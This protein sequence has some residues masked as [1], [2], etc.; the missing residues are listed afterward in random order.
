MFNS[1]SGKRDKDAGW[2]SPRKRFSTP[3]TPSKGLDSRSTSGEDPF[4]LRDGEEDDQEDSQDLLELADRAEMGL[5]REITTNFA[6]PVVSMQRCIVMRKEGKLE[7]RLISSTLEIM[8]YARVSADRQKIDIFGFD[9]TEEQQADVSFRSPFSLISSGRTS[10]QLV[11][12]NCE[13]CQY[14]PKHAFCAC[15]GKQQVA[16]VRHSTKQ[17]G[18]GVGNCLDVS[19]PALA[20]DGVP[21]VWC[22]LMG[23]HDLGSPKSKE[24]RGEALSLITKSPSWNTEFQ[25]LVLEFIGRTVIA[26]PD[27]F[28]L[29]FPD[30]PDDVV[31]QYGKL[32][33]TTYALDFKQPLSIVQAFG[34]ALSTIQLM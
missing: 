14:S 31:C 7:Y 5:S 23:K 22:P 10:W 25:C 15:S 19:I 3:S 12:E 26:S 18:N 20:S 1:P 2:F 33:E 21:M 27:N 4:H 13:H 24:Q 9:P 6:R 32:G 30:D 17:L 16:N 28:Q 34:I 8:A 11:R 29:T